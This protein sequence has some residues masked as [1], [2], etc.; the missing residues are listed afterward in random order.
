[1]IISQSIYL[2]IH[3]IVRHNVY[4]SLS[5]FCQTPLLLVKGKKK[6]VACLLLFPSPSLSP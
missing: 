2:L 4:V 3:C 6:L 1:M 5:C